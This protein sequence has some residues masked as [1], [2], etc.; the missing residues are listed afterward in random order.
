[1]FPAPINQVS[2]IRVQQI[3]IGG[4]RQ[5]RGVGTV[6]ENI[7]F[8]FE[9]PNYANN[10]SNILLAAD[11]QRRVNFYD[12][13]TDI[14]L[15]HET[16]QAQMWVNMVNWNLKTGVEGGSVNFLYD[17]YQQLSAIPSNQVPIG[18]VKM[19]YNIAS[20]KVRITFKNNHAAGG[21]PEFAVSI[22]HDYSCL[23]FITESTT[24]QVGI[25]GSGN[26]TETFIEGGF[27]VSREDLRFVHV[28]LEGIEPLTY[29]G[30]FNSLRDPIPAIYSLPME[31]EGNIESISE[32]N[33]EIGIVPFFQQT[34]ISRFRLFLM[35]EKRR[36]V[37]EAYQW[38]VVVDLYIPRG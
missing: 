28:C 18:F 29:E 35:D 4:L 21:Y 6:H 24:Q 22:P 14:E 12:V 7:Q 5:L 37:P 38:R 15:P 13:P 36:R 3:M 30:H 20:H 31:A 9:D 27:P 23:G 16:D 34:D 11:S 2:G 25:L 26:G 32:T 1:M 17:V 33:Q 10:N 8:F 19:E